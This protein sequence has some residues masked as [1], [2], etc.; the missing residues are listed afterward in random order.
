MLANDIMGL[1]LMNNPQPGNEHI[2]SFDAADAN[3]FTIDVPLKLALEKK[4]ALKVFLQCEGLPVS[5]VFCT[6]FCFV[7][8]SILARFA[9]TVLS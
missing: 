5:W 4:E 9:G 3:W 8:A 1:W 2:P 7:E 6:Y